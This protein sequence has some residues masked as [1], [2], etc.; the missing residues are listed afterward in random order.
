MTESIEDSSSSNDATSVNEDELNRFTRTL[1]EFTPVIPET[2]TKFYMRQCGL[3][4]EDERVVKLLSASVQKFMSGRVFEPSNELPLISLIIG[5][6]NDCYQ[7]QK[8]REKSTARPGGNATATTATASTVQPATTEATVSTT[9]QS[10]TAAI[11]KKPV[12]STNQTLN[13]NDLTQVLGDYGINVK[14]TFYYT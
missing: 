2:V 13:L 9:D 4:S 10:V 12:A 14:K 3:Q 11:A 8:L 7:L 1:D 6:I 5:I